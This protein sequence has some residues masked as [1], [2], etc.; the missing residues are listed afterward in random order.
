MADSTPPSEQSQ[1]KPSGRDPSKRAS[2]VLLI[3]EI[4]IT[5]ILLGIVV[6]KI[7][8]LSR[9]LVETKSASPSM[10]VPLKEGSWRFVV[11]GDSR[12][13]GDL[14][15]P[16]I[17]AQ[18]IEKYQ[19]A[20]YWHLGDLRAIYKIDED[21]AGAAQKTGQALSCESYHKTAWQDFIDHQI[22]PFGT[23]RFY[24]G[25]GNHEVIP[26][27]SKAEFSMQFKD[28]LLTPRLQMQRQDMAE[29][30]AAKTGPCGK[31]ARQPYLTA[32]TYYHWIRNQVD[33]IYL[34]NSS[35]V[36]SSDQLDWFDC[37][38]DRAHSNDAV[39]AVVVGMHE[40]LPASRA[41]NHAMCDDSIQDPIVKKQSC[42][43]GTHV[44][45]ALVEFNKTKHAYL[46][47]SHSHFYMKGIFDN[48]PSATR[49]DGW[50]VGTAGAVRY[51]LPPGTQPGPDAFTDHY[52]YLL[53]TV[54]NGD[55]RFEFQE[56]R[57]SDIPQ[58]ARQQYPQTVVSWCFVKNSQNQDPASEETTNRCNARTAPIASAKPG[59]K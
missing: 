48:Q 1:D 7:G 51:P 26:P 58:A 29:I 12:N 25:I 35:S 59:K 28:W 5:V 43:S 31:I 18:A 44:Y 52:G 32:A 14:V 4:A 41:S 20:F 6:W 46:L 57:E 49:L 13:C 9:L 40:A 15:M 33:F 22:V 23:T 45:D 50:I 19:P 3:I 34:D 21:M 30:G 11:S 53:G 42:E 39:K 16:A 8:P 56:V 54:E 27:K 37:I 10:F 24:L 17:A 55:I 38:L 2:T 36:F 47:A